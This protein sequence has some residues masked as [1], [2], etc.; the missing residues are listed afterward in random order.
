MVQLYKRGE[1]CA[2]E[3]VGSFNFDNSLP[4]TL[5]LQKTI[6]VHVL[7]LKPGQDL[8]KEI[9]AYVQQQNIKAGWIQTC[10]G[11]LTQGHL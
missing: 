1:A 4:N 5:M 11:S 10:V 8:R 6:K 3:K 7:R 9:E 2:F